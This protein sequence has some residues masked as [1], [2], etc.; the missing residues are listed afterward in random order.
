MAWEKWEGEDGLDKEWARREE[1]KKR[2][3]EQKFEQGLKE[4]VSAI[5][6]SQILLGRSM[7]L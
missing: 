2:K 5:L 3:R 4:S 1:F 6:P 7:S